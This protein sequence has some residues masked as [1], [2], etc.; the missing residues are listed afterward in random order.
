MTASSSDK[1]RLMHLVL[2]LDPGGTQRLV[3]EMSKRL[4]GQAETRV[5]CLDQEGDWAG[6]LLELDI[7]V[8]AL[9]REPGFRPA[10][11]AH[12]ARLARRHDLHVLHCHHYSPFVYGALATRLCSGLRL[13]YTEHGRHADSPP[14]RKRRLANLLLARV[15]GR[16][17]AVSEE[18]RT[19]ML[20]EG[21]ASDR[22]EV[23][24]NGI[25]PGQLPTPADRA[26]ARLSLGL[27]SDA[28]VVG[29]VARLDPVKDLTTLLE[30]FH[31]FSRAQAEAAL[32]VI[33]DGPELERLESFAGELGIESRISF[34]GAR[35]DVR[36][37]LAGFDVYA[38]TSTTEGVSVT[39][40]EAMASGL[41]VVATAVG[42]TPEVVVHEETGLLVPAREPAL[43]AASLLRLAG[44]ADLRQRLGR[45]G[46]ERLS[47][48]FTLE[49]MVGHYLRIY[50][51]L[52]DAAAHPQPHGDGPR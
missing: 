50:S 44:D 27:S 51:S 6:E 47:R 1:L 15:P 2:D 42:G 37:L 26:D 43:L 28:L 39:I 17:F 18:L 34:T 8:V 14:S 11:A 23:V 21:F 45:A 16:F 9:G 36:R 32:V 41:P 35:N 24:Y 52:P 19:H 46:R 20:A 29:T 5:C 22:L 31:V 3:I 33:G 48:D 4:R 25:D 38:N 13:V 30:A 49:K 40:L 7:P 12:L 10:L